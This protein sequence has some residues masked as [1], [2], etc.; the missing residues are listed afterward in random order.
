MIHIEEDLGT[1]QIT[2]PFFEGMNH[3]QELLLRGGVVTLRRE[4]LL[5]SECNRVAILLKDATGSQERSICNNLKGK[6]KIRR[7]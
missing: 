6:R 5:A 4:V 7:T 1:L 2:A 3:T